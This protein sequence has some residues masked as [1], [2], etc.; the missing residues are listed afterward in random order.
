ME[1]MNGFILS[2]ILEKL[3]NHFQQNFEIKYFDSKNK[4]D[5][6]IQNKLFGRKIEE[7]GN[8]NLLLD[9]G[10]WQLYFSHLVVDT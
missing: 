5:G 4:K 10:Y 1:F 7:I 9:A 2:P 8:P 3:R 6:V